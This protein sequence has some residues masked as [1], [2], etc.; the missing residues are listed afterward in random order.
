MKGVKQLTIV[1]GDNFRYIMWTN[2]GGFENFTPWVVD[3][4]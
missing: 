2:K 4:R 1:G 3:R